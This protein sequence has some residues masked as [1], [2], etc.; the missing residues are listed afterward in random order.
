MSLPSNF[1]ASVIASCADPSPCDIVSQHGKRIIKISDNKVVKWGP[2]ITN[3]EAENQRIAYNIVDSRIA[4]IPRAYAFFSD[5]RGWGYIVMEFIEGKIIDPLEDDA[6]IRKVAGVLDH[7]STLG[8]T[9]PGSLCG[10]SCRG[11][12]FPETEDLLFNSLEDMEKWFNSRLFEHDPKLSFQDSNL[13]LCHLDIALRN[14]LWQE[15]GPPCIIDW[16]SAGFYPRLFEFC[17]QWVIEGKDGS[18][19]SRL[20]NSMQPL[21]DRET[22]QKDAFLCSWRNIQKYPLRAKR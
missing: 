13:V 12:L 3:E 22:A 18:Y 21:S 4:R 7:F 1:Q 10:G 17:A 15:D 2:D 11:L 19:N 8:H 14:I 20:L 5:E 9:I 16:A 6:A